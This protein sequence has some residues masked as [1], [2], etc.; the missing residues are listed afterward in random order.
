GDQGGKFGNGYNKLAQADTNHDGQL[1]GAELNGIKVWKDNGDGKVQAGEIQTMAQ[2]G[3]NQ[4]STGV[5]NVQNGRGENL[6]LSSFVQ[7][8]QT[9]F[10]FFSSRRR[11][12]RYWRDW[13]SDVCSSDLL[14]TVRFEAGDPGVL[15][16][17]AA[18]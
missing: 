4:L 8:G 7:N 9:F 14:R 2:Q 5:N 15:R 12:T 18:P 16:P 10:F 6:M 17:E 13:S 1:T 11:H 3:I